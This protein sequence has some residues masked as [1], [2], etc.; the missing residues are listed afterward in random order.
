MFS[1]SN[2]KTC[3][4]VLFLIYQIAQDYFLKYHMDYTDEIPKLYNCFDESDIEA[5]E[6]SVDEEQEEA[7]N[8]ESDNESLEFS[9][10]PIL[11]CAE[12]IKTRY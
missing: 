2:L 6:E 1:I 3:L 8:I 10:V 9:L 5:E 4:I 7:N 11:D 12:S